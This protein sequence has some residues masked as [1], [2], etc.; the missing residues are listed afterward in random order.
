M[1][2]KSASLIAHQVF[3][4]ERIVIYVYLNTGDENLLKMAVLTT[5]WRLNATYRCAEITDLYLHL[6]GKW[7]ENS[8]HYF[9]DPNVNTFTS[10]FTCDLCTNVE[11]EMVKIYSCYILGTNFL[12][13]RNLHWMRI[14]ET[15]EWTVPSS[16]V[17]VF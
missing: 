7:Y 17:Q 14:Y 1:A 11:Q 12:T 9:F 3:T 5:S 15:V 16:S 2:K 6:E 4:F 8:Y 13:D 10:S